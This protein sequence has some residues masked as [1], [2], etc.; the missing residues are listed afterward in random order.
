[1]KDFLF[2]AHFPIQFLEFVLFEF[3]Y[4]FGQYFL[5]GIK[6]NFVDKT[7]LLASQQISG[8][9]NFKIFHG[10]IETAAQICK[11]LQG[12]NSFSGIVGH[13][14]IGGGNKIT[15]GLLIAPPY[16]SPHLMQVA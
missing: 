8:T 4:G 10:N 9:P 1:Y 2:A 11:L 5:I 12:L 15:E 13:Y 14:I 16:T 3:V 7:T 6:A